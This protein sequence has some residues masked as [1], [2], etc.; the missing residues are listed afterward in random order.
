MK[1]CLIG[2]GGIALSTAF[3]LINTGNEVV[4]YTSKP[5]AFNGTISEIN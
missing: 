4:F 5:N 1:I 2:S 3:D